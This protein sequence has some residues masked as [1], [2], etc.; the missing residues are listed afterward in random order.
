[1]T[2][3]SPPRGSEWGGGPNRP[4]RVDRFRQRLLALLALGCAFGVSAPVQ[5][6][7]TSTA[8]VGQVDD[9]AAFDRLFDAPAPSLRRSRAQFIEGIDIIGNVKTTRSVIERR[10]LV[11]SGDLVDEEK[12]DESRLRLLNT[13]F[14]KRVEMSL[15]RGS[16]PGQV[17]L[18]V[19]VEERNTILIDQLYLGFSTVSPF[20]GGFGLAETNFLGRGVTVAG[21]FVV[22]RDRRGGEVRL[23][24]PY[25]SDTPIQLS[26]SAI[27]VQGAEAV[28]DRDATGPKLFYDR[29]GGTLGFGVGVGP[30]QR[31]SLIYRL[32]S[33]QA[34]RLPLTLTPS[35]IRRAPSILSDESVLSTLALTY[36]RDTR[37]DPFVPTSGSRI[38][39]AVEMGTTLIGSSYEFS[40]YTGEVQKAFLAFSEHSLVFRG[41]GGIIQGETPFFNQFFLGDFAYFAW[42]RSSLPRNAQINFSESNDYDDLIFSVGADYSIPVLTQE[43]VLYRMFVY[44]GIDVSMTAS[45]DELQEDRT[46]RGIG[47]TFPLSFDLG[48]KFDTSFGNFTLSMSYLFEL[49]Y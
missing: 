15:R 8:S 5:A 26:A 7:D 33:V 22:G 47:R 25:L 27:F 29:W 49:V 43:D 2:R 9:V 21:G 32:E 34:D 16:R 38:A 23:F 10:L 28:D 6:A 14:F 41:F 1:M 30:A 24:V 17:L 18:V 44:A 35:V 39:L 36:E 19:E 46:G 20:F 42:N 31:V 3:L 11:G 45:L 48:M 37:D 12:V 40:K 13:G 4:T